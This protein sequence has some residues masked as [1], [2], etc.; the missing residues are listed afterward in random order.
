MKNWSWIPPSPAFTTTKR[1]Q[2]PRYKFQ[3]LANLGTAARPVFYEV[4]QQIGS[5]SGFDAYNLYH[6]SADS[7]KYYDTKISPYQN[8]CLFW[9]RGTGIKLDVEFVRNIKPNWNVGIAYRT[10]RAKENF[11]SN[12]QGR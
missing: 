9:W 12:A 2:T 4:P 8:C 6:N 11:K 1:W 7:I 5:T 10:I 3:D